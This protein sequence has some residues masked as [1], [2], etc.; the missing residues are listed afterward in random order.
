M[1]ALNHYGKGIW[2][3]SSILI[4]IIAGYLVA[5]A[6][7]LVDFGAVA[8]ASFFQLPRPL[9]FGV[10]FE[11]SSCIAIGI[12]FAINSIQAIGDF[13]PGWCP[14]QSPRQWPAW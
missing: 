2:K 3:L 4:G 1:T 8:G 12:L 9:H 5:L 13:R 14:L 7:G 6:F 10:I 11:P